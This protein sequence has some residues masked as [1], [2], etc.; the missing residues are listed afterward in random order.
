MI[1]MGTMI[2]KGA[3]RLVAAIAVLLYGFMLYLAYIQW[4]QN[5]F[6][7]ESW[8]VEIFY[9]LDFGVFGSGL[10]PLMLAIYF[11]WLGKTVKDLVCGFVFV[12]LSIIIHYYISGW[13]AH[14]EPVIYVP[15]QFIELA[16]VIALIV[17]WRKKYRTP[18]KNSRDKGSVTLNLLRK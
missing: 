3:A 10:P 1:D 9:V 4:S 18:L 11:L 12:L 7:H 8:G 17:Y 13:A 2:L 16:A 5:E 6:A 15:M 14:S